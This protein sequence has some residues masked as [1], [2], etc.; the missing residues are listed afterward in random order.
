MAKVNMRHRASIERIYSPEAFASDAAQNAVTTGQLI[1]GV[2]ILSRPDA[3]GAF[4]LEPGIRHVGEAAG[5]VFLA[6]HR[7]DGASGATD[8]Q[9]D[10]EKFLDEIIS[11]ARRFGFE[12]AQ[13]PGRGDPRLRGLRQ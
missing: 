13:A 11:A 7:R 1:R 9:A 6:P 3:S 12:P 5:A 4:D 10:Y 8:P 2:R